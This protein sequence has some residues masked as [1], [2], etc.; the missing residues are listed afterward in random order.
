MKNFRNFYLQAIPSK[1]LRAEIT[2]L[3]ALP[4]ELKETIEVERINRRVVYVRASHTAA[5]SK[6][7]ELKEELVKK[8]NRIAGKEIIQDIRVI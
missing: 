6:V 2:F 5:A 4:E 8:A 3:M 1:K 7:M